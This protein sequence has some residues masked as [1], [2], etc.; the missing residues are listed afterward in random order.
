M[1]FILSTNTI[2]NTV[3]MF[4]KILT[5]IFILTLSSDP[6]ALL[7]RVISYFFLQGARMSNIDHGA[8]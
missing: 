6:C 8:A 7:V 2:I 4:C 5:N 1:V 3:A